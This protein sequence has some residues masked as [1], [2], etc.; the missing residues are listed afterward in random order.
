[1]LNLQLQP[2]LVEKRMYA[3]N[4]AIQTLRKTDCFGDTRFPVGFEW[5]SPIDILQMPKNV[6]I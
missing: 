2:S 4:E 1:M 3:L 5:P 6:P